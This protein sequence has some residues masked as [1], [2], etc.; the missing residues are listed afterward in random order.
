MFRLRHVA[1]ITSLMLWTGAVDAYEDLVGDNLAV[2]IQL[3]ASIGAD[4]V[5]QQE[6]ELNARGVVGQ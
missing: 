6:N 5:A 1:L 4:P 2:K 3:E